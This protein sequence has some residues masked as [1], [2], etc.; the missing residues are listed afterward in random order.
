MKISIITVSYNSANTIEQTIRSVINQ[1]YNNIEYIIIDGGS[2]DG[3]V[4]I[5]EKYNKSI[6]YWCSESDNG[7]YYAMNKGINLA[8]GDY[9]QILGSD[10]CLYEK[11]TIKNVVESMDEDIDIFSASRY[12]VFEKYKCQVITGNESARH[13]KKGRLPWM[14]HTS[15]FVRTEYMKKHLFDTSYKIAADY[16]F[17]LE[18]Y[19]DENVKFQYVDYPVAYFSLSGISNQ[20]TNL[21]QE[22]NNRLIMEL[23]LKDYFDVKKVDCGSNLWK[24]SIKS[25]LDY[26][27]ILGDV[28]CIISDW[29]KHRCNNEWCR[30]CK[31]IK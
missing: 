5:L 16:K 28:L 29:E 12:E 30:W 9:I 7:I 18:A 4:N 21:Q 22:E 8:T 11:D 19:M 10:D 20:G 31:N 24:K 23:N 14:P 26:C 6:S 3:T 27:G 13:M 2:K 1:S 25:F 15:V 17:L